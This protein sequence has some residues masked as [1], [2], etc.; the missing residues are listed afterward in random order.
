M[1]YYDSQNDNQHEPLRKI[2]RRSYRGYFLIGL[3]GAVL[4]V[5]I[6]MVCQPYLMKQ[7]VSAEKSTVQ[8]STNTSSAPANVQTVNV[9][10]V[11]FTDAVS[12]TIDS[13]VGVN[14][15]QQ[16]NSFGGDGQL[17][18]SST[19][20]GVIYKKDGNKAYIVTNNHVIEGAS[21]VEVSLKNKTKLK[22]KILGADPLM[23]LAVL[24][25]QGRNLPKAAELGNSN[26]LKPGE[27]VAT[28]GNPL[29]YLDYSITQGIVSNPQRE[30]PIDINQDQSYDW[31]ADVIQTD[32]SINP[33]NSGGALIN[34]A[35]QL[36][37]INSMKIAEQGVEGIGFAIPVNSALPIINSLEKDGKVNRPYMGIGNKSL[38]EISLDDRQQYLRLPQSVKSGVVVLQV[39]PNSPAAR[40]G[41]Q[42]RDVITALNGQKIEN[43]VGLRK[44]LYTKTKI[45]DR[46]TVEY[47]RNGQKKTTQMTLS[48]D[49]QN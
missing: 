28:I 23:D 36:V 41:I 27:P 31:E 5:V 2:Y 10:N 8:Q 17:K 30:I 45:G 16:D 40:A 32:A 11:N 44:F 42:E 33:G 25:I 15:Y 29:G 34:M 37:G 48:V 39:G 9:K 19:G 49:Q 43:A 47:Y 6:M 22:A 1:G 38:D 20:S 35:G 18:E 24:E 13:V 7:G 3:V 46:I 21:Q 26:A 12:K 14:N 4:G